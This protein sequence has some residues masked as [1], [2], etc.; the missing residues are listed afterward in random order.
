MSIAN[1]IHDC[2]ICC[3]DIQA[4][5]QSIFKGPA[6]QPPFPHLHV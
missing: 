6:A 2:A 3:W 4:L 5:G 1:N